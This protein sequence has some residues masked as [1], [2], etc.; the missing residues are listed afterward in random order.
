MIKN[1]KT[2]RMIKIGSQQHHKTIALGYLS[3]DT[4]QQPHQEKEKE[5]EIDPRFTTE[6]GIAEICSDIISNKQQEFKKLSQSDTDELIR[7]LLYKKL[8]INKTKSKSKSS[9]LKKSKKYYSSDSD[10]SS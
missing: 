10:D 7:E 4:L 3:P 1:P 8:C 9:K 5:K 6:T 2:N